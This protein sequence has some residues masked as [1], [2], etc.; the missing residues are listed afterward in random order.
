MGFLFTRLLVICNGEHELSKN[1]KW[2]NEDGET[3]GVM[4]LY[5]LM[6][7]SHR[8]KLGLVLQVLKYKPELPHLLSSFFMRFKHFVLDSVN[9]LVLISYSSSLF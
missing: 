8:G 4:Q 2:V 6:F 5:T 3:A 7:G 1:R 9:L